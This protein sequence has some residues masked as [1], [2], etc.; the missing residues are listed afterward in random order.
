MSWYL[1][2][3][4]KYAIV[5]KDLLVTTL[6]EKEVRSSDSVPPNLIWEIFESIENKVIDKRVII[7][8]KRK[9]LIK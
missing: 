3:E 5:G 7:K 8:L 6:N 1:S 4:V 2:N 9:L